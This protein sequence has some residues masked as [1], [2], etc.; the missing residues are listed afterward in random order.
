MR[1]GELTAC[2]SVDVMGQT[3][4]DVTHKYVM[5]SWRHCS[6]LTGE[7]LISIAEQTCREYTTSMSAV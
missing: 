7:D 2:T 4:S 6:V 1:R 5:L 3:A